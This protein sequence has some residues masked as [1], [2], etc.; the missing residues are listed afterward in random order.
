[1]S[2]FSC[3][4]LS[5]LGNIKISVNTGVVTGVSFVDSLSQSSGVDRY[6]EIFRQFGEYFEGKRKVFDINFS[7]LTGTEF[8]KA[9]WR[10][11]QKIPYGKTVTYSDIAKSLGDKNLARAVGNSCNKNPIAIIVPCH[12][13]VPKNGSMSGGYA[14]GTDIKQKLLSLEREYSE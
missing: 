7:F 14:Y 13:V 6:P 11:L 9:V 1:M 4:Y 3:C 5:P 10:E 8:N 12:R 2:E